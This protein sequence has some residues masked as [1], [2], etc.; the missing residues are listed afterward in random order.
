MPVLWS[1]TLTAF[2]EFGIATVT[3][4]RRRAEV[5]ARPKLLPCQPRQIHER[6]PPLRWRFFPARPWPDK[7]LRR[8]DA[9]GCPLWTGQ[10]RGFNRASGGVEGNRGSDETLKSATRPRRTR[11]RGLHWVDFRARVY[12]FGGRGLQ[13]VAPDSRLLQCSKGPPITSYILVSLRPSPAHTSRSPSSN[14][15]I[16]SFTTCLWNSGRMFLVD[17]GRFNSKD[18]STLNRGPQ[19][20]IEAISLGRPAKSQSER[21]PELA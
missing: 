11:D 20:L 19:Y 13:C 14:E 4:S 16:S 2:S 7:H 3:S 6:P 12:W 9:R 15:I 18:L 17:A 21:C 1:T 10:H 8:I 5:I